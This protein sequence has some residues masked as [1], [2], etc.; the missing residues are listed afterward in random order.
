MLAL[1]PLVASLA[2]TAAAPGGQAPAEG[3]AVLAERARAALAASRDAEA[4]EAV[5]SALALKPDWDEGLWYLGTLEYQAGRRDAADA[6][7]ARFLELKPQT[8]AAWVLRGFCS[9]EGGDYKA[10]ADRLGRGLS[11]G[12]GGN[13]ELETLGR[14][15]LATAVVKTYDFEVAIPPLTLLARADPARPEVVT[16]VGLAL[17]RMPLLPTEIPPARRDL[18]LKTG[19]AGA[20]HLAEHGEEAD[21]AFAELVAAYPGEPWVHYAQGVFLRRTDSDRALAAFRRELEVNPTNVLAC[22]DIAFELLQLRRY[23][24]A[25]GVAE[26]AVAMAPTLFASHAALG[27]ARLELGEVEPAISA[28]EQATRLAP[29]AAEVHFALARAYARAGRE[30]DA[31]RER[32][33]FTRLD[34]ARKAAAGPPAAA[35]GVRP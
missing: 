21:R 9:F 4:L 13:R 1:L 31:A 7:F 3:F 8:G 5:R 17:L 22:L 30:S 10:A 23:E 20:L 24:E 29:E 16:L 19:R 28:L 18:V 32:A 25:R 15:R 34:E 12:L 26:R 14:L 2:L 33:E 11:L 6:A 35:S 27:R